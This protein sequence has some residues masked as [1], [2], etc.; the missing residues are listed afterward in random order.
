MHCS[1]LGSDA[2]KK[3]IDDYLGKHPE[4]AAVVRPPERSRDEVY[5]DRFGPPPTLPADAA[6]SSTMHVITPRRAGCT[7]HDGMAC[8]PFCD[9][10]IPSDSHTCEP[11]GK[12]LA[13]CPNCNALI[14][15]GAHDCP[16]CGADLDGEH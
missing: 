12:D 11:C 16:I 1:N 6:A 13:H 4:I 8:C 5:A 14:G 15:K 10:E 2:L 3:A 9:A 7:P